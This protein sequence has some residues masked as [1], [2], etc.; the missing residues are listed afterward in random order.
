MEQ[1]TFF[2][3]LIA[4]LRALLAFGRHHYA[5]RKAV[6][7]AYT[8]T[9][10]E[11]TANQRCAIKLRIRTCGS[12]YE[13]SQECFV[14]DQFKVRETWMASYGW[15]SNGHLMAIGKTRYIIF[16]PVRKLVVLEDYPDTGAGTVEIYHQ[17]Q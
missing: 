13:V 9:W 2:N 14:N 12:L 8:R 15:H 16:D 4:A 3:R 11:A 1:H 17:D 10:R 5:S 7:F 6:H